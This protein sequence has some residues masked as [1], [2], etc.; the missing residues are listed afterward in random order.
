MS[1]TENDSGTVNAIFTVQLSASSSQTI[2][3]D[4]ATA[5]GTATAGT[6]Y[7]A[8]SGTLSFAPGQTT[9]TIP[10]AIK[11]DQLHEGNENFQLILSAPTNATIAD[12]IGVC[13]I[14]NND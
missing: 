2:T 1:L 10:V 14:L 6:D 3:V 5:D 13:T 4:F 9:K 7:I 11:G 12:G 8:T